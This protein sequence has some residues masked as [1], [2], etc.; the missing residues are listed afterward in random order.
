MKRQLKL[1]IPR[2]KWFLIRLKLA[3]KTAYILFNRKGLD[4]LR[5]AYYDE[6]LAL[7]RTQPNGEKTIRLKGK[8]ELLD[9]LINT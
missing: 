3:S 1:I 6:F 2:L 7:E 5:K 4:D 9:Q 8:V